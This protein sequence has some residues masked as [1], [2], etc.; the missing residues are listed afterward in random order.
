[1]RRRLP[2]RCSI[3]PFLLERGIA[4]R[5]GQR[6]LRANLWQAACFLGMTY[7][8]LEGVGTAITIPT[9]SGT[10]QM[11]Y[12]SIRRRLARDEHDTCTLVRYSVKL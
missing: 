6:F 1:M 11:R 9:S 8:M 2:R 5:Q 12:R 3:H 4:V 10:P 7:E